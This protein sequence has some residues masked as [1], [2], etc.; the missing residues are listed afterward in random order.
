M[1][2]TALSR[3]EEA[4]CDEIS[5][6]SFPGRVA[7][8]GA[9]GARGAGA[10][11]GP[12]RA[13]ASGEVD[14]DRT[15]YDLAS[16]SKVVGT[17]TAVMLLVEDG[18]MSLDDPV[19]AYLPEF[20]GHRQGPRHHPPPAHAHLGA[21]RRRRRAP[22]ARREEG[23][24][25]ADAR[26]AG[27][28]AGDAGGVLGRGLRRPL[29][30]GGAGGGRAAVPAAG[31]PRLRAAGDDVARRTWWAR[32]ACAAP[33]PSRDRGDA[34]RGRCTIPSRGGWAASA[35]NAGLF[36]TAHDMARFAAMM[37][38]GGALDGVRVLR[39]STIRAFTPAPAGDGHPRAGMGHAGRAGLRR[40]G[41]ARVATARSGTRASRAP[42][43]GSIR[44][45]APGWCCWPTAPTRTAPTACRRCA[46]RC[47]TAWP[48]RCAPQRPRDDLHPDRQ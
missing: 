48:T 29:R 33:A 26:A 3:A 18:K 17:T 15:V 8:R 7:R 41:D 39:A 27:A 35:G 34:Y 11:D 12:H 46:A 47:T 24:A 9:L 40:L 5:R 2:A 25:A 32:G 1:S 31:P 36:S 13:P 16:L 45:A 38:N 37:A 43:S 19:Q 14:P 4:V 22:A 44:S 28:R 23:A 20:T 30:R 10:G 6:G 21:A 42:P